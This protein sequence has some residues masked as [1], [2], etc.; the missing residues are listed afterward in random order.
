MKF[1]IY[2]IKHNYENNTNIVKMASYGKK[3]KRIFFSNVLKEWERFATV[4]EQWRNCWLPPVIDSVCTPGLDPQY[5]TPA[6]KRQ[7]KAWQ[8]S[9]ATYI[10]PK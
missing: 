4:S 6:T 3:N 5:T 2:G 1:K 9:N 7:S 10:R 8:P